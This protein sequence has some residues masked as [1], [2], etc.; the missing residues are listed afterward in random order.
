MDGTIL[1]LLLV[2]FMNVEQHIAQ[3]TNLA[4]FIPTAIVACIVNAKQKVINYKLGIKIIISGVIGAVI[5]AVISTNINSQNL[6]KYF[7]IFLLII[8]T[9]E[10]ITI[11]LKY[12][13]KS[14]TNNKNV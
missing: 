13:R 3:A 9:Y 5:G 14:K 12:I 10:I 8:E 7:G 1:I 11:I 6:K 2:T 4:F